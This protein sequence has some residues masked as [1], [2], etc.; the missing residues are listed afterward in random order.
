MRGFF[1]KCFIINQSIDWNSDIL[2][3]LAEESG[4]NKVNVI[5][6]GGGSMCEAKFLPSFVAVC[7]DDVFSIRVL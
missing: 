1:V 2:A 7:S 5:F 6:P 3:V 4:V